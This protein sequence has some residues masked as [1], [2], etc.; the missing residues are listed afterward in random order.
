MSAYLTVRY[1]LYWLES[2]YF[3]VRY[4]LYWLV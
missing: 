2:A 3:T 4:C 1:C